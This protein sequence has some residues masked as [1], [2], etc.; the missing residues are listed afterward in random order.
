MTGPPQNVP[1]DAPDFFWGVSTSAYQIEGAWNE[2]GKGASIWD[3]F[4]HLPGAIAG[5]QTGDVACDHYHRWRDDLE[6]LRV[7]GVNAYRFSVAWSRILPEGR[8]RVNSAGFDFYDRLV[9]GLLALGIQPFPTLYHWDLPQ[10]LQDAGGWPQ[11]D[12]AHAFADYAA[13]VSRRLGDR[14]RWWT[15][16]NEPFVAAILGHFTGE[17]APGLKDPRAALQAAHHLL[18]SHGEAVP[19]LRAAAPAPVRV[20]IALNLQPV[21]PASSS[22]EDTQAARR[23]DGMVNR[24]FLEPLFHGSY[25]RDLL[26]DL[27]PLAPTVPAADFERIAAPLDFLGVNYYSRFVARHNPRQPV[28]GVEQVQPAGAEASALWEI[29]PAGLP[30]LLQRLKRAYAPPALLITENG[31]PLADSPDAEGEVH[32]APR[33]GY[34]AR[35]LAGVR[36]AC[37]AGVPVRGYFVWSLLDNFEWA[38][39]YAM[40]FGLVYVDFATQ[41]RILKASARWYRRVI[42]EA[43]RVTRRSSLNG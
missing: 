31:M 13:T 2:A 20:G 24:W 40:R 19:A 36:Q 39:G 21:H 17:H 9:D 27:G 4:T 30:E 7:L 28:L 38:F 32:D 23:F 12:T 1:P 37:A 6:L 34:L 5:G 10:A 16:H 35:H 18:L 33:I 11:R 15:T 26:E 14:V 3:T 29:Y 42:D 22:P 41:R 43:L 8:G 25:P